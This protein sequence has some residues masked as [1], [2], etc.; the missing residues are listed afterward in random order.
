[1]R[2]ISLAS[3]ITLASM[4]VAKTNYVTRYHYVTVDEDGNI[5]GTDV[6]LGQPTESVQAT[7][8]VSIATTTTIQ[9]NGVSQQS[10]TTSGIKTSVPSFI[11]IKSDQQVTES[12]ELTG[13]AVE[14]TS[15]TKSQPISQ[16]PE[17]SIGVITETTSST[18]PETVLASTS[19]TPTSVETNS[20]I[21]S[22][23]SSSGV[24]VDFAKA[25]LDAHNTKRASHSASAL[26]WSAALFDYAQNYANSYTCGSMLIHSGGKYGENL[27]Y[28]YSSGVAALEAWYS[29][30]TGY[31]YANANVLDHFTQVIWKST[32]KLGCAYKSCGGGLYVI[33]S[34]DPA[35]NFVGEESANLSAN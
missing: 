2:L 9:D 4:A 20:G 8:P 14:A 31:D 18:S 12:T 3:T 5:L 32:T 27:A 7:Q 23:I 16:T 6:V 29:E 35:G 10:T 25:I 19:T 34:Y 24:D 17:V 28:G 26:S 15:Q 13:P 21:Y 1:M 22:E 30:G 11:D 33:C